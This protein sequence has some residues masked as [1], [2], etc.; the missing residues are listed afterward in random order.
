[1]PSD[2]RDALRA[3]SRDRAFTVLAVLL[4][5]LTIGATGGV[6]AVVDAVLL[7]P[8]AFADQDRTVVVWQRDN[9]RD[10]P[11]VELA[12]GEAE[13]WRQHATAFEDLAVFGSVNWPLTVVDGDSRTRVPY[14]AVSA[15]FF[16]VAGTP[17]ALGRVLEASDEVGNRPRAA[18]I[19]EAFWRQH[20]GASS[21]V[22][23]QV[24]RA[25]D[26]TAIPDDSAD[27]ALEI[28]GVMPATFDF[29]R[30][31][32]LWLPA[33]PIIRAVARPNPNDPADVAW[34]LANFRV[35][36]GLGRLRPGSSAAL[37]GQE[38]DAIIRQAEVASP[39]GTPSDAVVT[40]LDDYLVGPAKPVLWLMLAGAALMVLL[41]SG[42]VAGLH[43]FRAARQDRALA[44]QMALGASRGR[45]IRRSL[46]ESALLA[47]VG[48]AGAVAI[49]WA[50]TRLLTSAAPLDVPRLDTVG[51]DA[52]PVL[53][54]VVALALLSGLLSGAWPAV[55]ITRVDA[56]PALTSGTRTAMHPR[57][58]LLQ[59][60]VVGWQVAI[61]VVV[62]TGAGLFLRSVQQLD[63][64]A[65]GFDP[66]GLLAM[67]V[68]P[69]RQ[70]Q[71]QWDQLYDA[72]L[73]RVSAMPHVTSASAV[74]LRP[75]R[76]PIGNDTIP[77]LE[78]Q[79]GLG[80]DAPWRGNPRANLESTTPGYFRTLGARMLAGRDFSPADR[81]A[82]PNVV[83]VSASAAARYWP[84]R[85][86]IGQ[87][88]VV[89]TQRIPGT[90]EELRWQTVVGVVEDVRYRGLTDPRL[91]VYLPAAQSTMRVKHLM[92]RT[93][94]DPG[95]LAGSIRAIALGLDPGAHIGETVAMSDEVA[96]ES[97]PWR[98]AMHV[99]TGFGVLAAG[100]ATAGLTGL[101]S[102]MVTLRRRE[103]GI[104]A[105]LGATPRRL[106]AH[107]LTEAAR[108]MVVA[109]IVGVLCALALGRVVM[110]LLVDI[111]PHD[112]TSVVGA[113]ALTMLAG[114]AGCLWPAA[115]AAASDPMEALRE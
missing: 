56:G 107:V 104:R 18:V 11:V 42:S 81:A 89:P 12:M 103:L 115:R 17:P 95:S 73:A 48:A 100:L 63:R 8:M 67:E 96:R 33:A 35:F 80:P 97:A 68:E 70:D 13:T 102:L 65:L 76:G 82:A 98:F 59:R 37:A 94:V 90:R 31:A 99:L 27:G 113:V 58:R 105:A 43:L 60:L 22:L 72:L 51:M 29:P 9:A 109:T 14:A 110:G 101:V 74:Y 83:I 62:L 92:V 49:A 64:T 19:S 45:L 25:Q 88:I 84:G 55:F 26:L 28:V 53:M 52:R 87:P 47:G 7:R 114:M 106:R 71:D 4:F 16:A 6:F 50:V 41:A 39:A 3:L 15:S 20:F 85:D 54:A 34:Y 112:P 21:S 77:V 57:E 111:T 44:I 10:T 66:E 24:I 61:A 32:R 38:L 75:L 108:T 91:D 69:S 86:A 2:L 1:M 79:E 40:A 46:T 36:Y 5:A 93:T 23:G 78:G 30:G